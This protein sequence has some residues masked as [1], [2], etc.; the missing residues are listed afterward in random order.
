[1]LAG[2]LA[3]ATASAFAGAAFYIDLVEQPARLGLG[4][5]DLLAQWKASY[6]RGF[7]MQA[8]LAVV[9]GVLGLAAAW[10]TRDWRWFLGAI[11]VLANWPYTLLGIMAMNNKLTAI[12]NDAAGPT[13][14]AMIANWGW[15]HAVRT[16]LGI[17]ATLVYLWAAN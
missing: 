4:D 1:M 8:S 17:A 10:Q 2:L 12:A 3:L 7:A 16:A 14:R 6:P 11:L 9:S 5:K 15:L 13:S